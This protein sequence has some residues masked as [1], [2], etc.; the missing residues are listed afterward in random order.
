MELGSSWVDTTGNLLAVSSSRASIAW[1]SQV[2]KEAETVSGRQ[3]EGYRWR[4]TGG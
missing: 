4:L 2:K 1:D 3:M